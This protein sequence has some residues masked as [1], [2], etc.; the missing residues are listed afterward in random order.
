[1][2]NQT[3]RVT[4]EIFNMST[5]SILEFKP[6][7]LKEIVPGVSS[8][9]RFLYRG[10]HQLSN[11]F[12]NCFLQLPPLV[13]FVYLVVV[14]VL[15]FEAC[16]LFLSL[17]LFPLLL[18]PFSLYSSLILINLQSPLCSCFSWPLSN[19]IKAK[20]GHLHFTF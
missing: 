13:F 14:L 12:S 2:Q 11:C 1:M 7:I 10:G 6:A 9:L 19:P 20:L 8:M 5:S 17:S 4:L 16:L 18:H 15:F 3:V